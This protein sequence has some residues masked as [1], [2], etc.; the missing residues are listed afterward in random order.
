MDK[1][2][3]IIIAA[4]VFIGVLALFY[5]TSG[6]KS[7]PQKGAF[8]GGE[9]PEFGEL[10][11][12]EASAGEAL[13]LMDSPDTL[14]YEKIIELAKNGRLNLVSEL[15]KFRRKCPKTGKEDKTI[16]EKKQEY[17]ACNNMIRQFI[18]A[19]FPPPGGKHLESIMVK[20]LEY[21]KL[22]STVDL[23][24][25]SPQD[26]YNLMKQKRRD[27]FGEEDTKLIFGLQETKV[28]YQ[29]TYTN[30]LNETKGLSGAERIKKYEEMRKEAYGDYYE[31]VAEREPKY[32]KYTVELDLRSEEMEKMK[33][34]GRIEEVTAMREKYFGKA[35]AERMAK[36]DQDIAKRKETEKKYAEA[37]NTFLSQN[38]ELSD[39]DREKQL[40]KLRVEHFGQEEAEAYTRRENYR[41]FMENVN[42]K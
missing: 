41:K 11:Q 20:Y 35:G 23:S 1:K 14:T 34:E 36:V 28:S 2:N 37:E 39:A 26:R 4:A 9:F 40:M 29:K 15:W 19:K 30:F 24:S 17:L 12:D 31:A 8:G 22:M 13:T 16:E 42:K 3:I 18:L 7:A 10:T 38:A 33:A 5:F 32:T 21:E 6:S 27:V 25:K